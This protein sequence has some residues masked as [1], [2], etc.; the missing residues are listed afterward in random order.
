MV[1]MSMGQQ[2]QLYLELIGLRKSQGW[3]AIRAGVEDHSLLRA[4]IPRQVGVDGH[5]VVNGIELRQARNLL[6]L[7]VPAFA[8]AL[9]QRAGAKVQDRRNLADRFQLGLSRFHPAQFVHRHARPFR[10]LIVA[11]PEPALRLADNVIKIIL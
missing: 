10:Q 8:G 6:V 7:R 9:D 3:G 11:Q 4:R 5:V 1:H 2:N